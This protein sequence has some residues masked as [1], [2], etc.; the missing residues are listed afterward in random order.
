MS[1]SHLLEAK[2]YQGVVEELGLTQ[3]P[4]IP[5]SDMDSTRT[6]EWINQY[7]MRYE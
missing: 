3:A 5:T 4:T 6:A 1:H 7:A 2:L